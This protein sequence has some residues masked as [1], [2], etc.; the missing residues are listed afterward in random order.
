MADIR[1]FVAVELSA[2]VIDRARSLIEH[3]RPS[4][5][6][7]KW[8]EPHNMHLTLQFL[9]DV[10]E[11]QTAE[12]CGAVSE[13]IKEFPSFDV[14][15]AGA[16]AFPDARRPRT[17]WIGVR[18]GIEPLTRLQAAIEAALDELGFPG[19]D[20]RF[21]PHLT[22]GRVRQGGGPEVRALGQLVRQHAD[23]DAASATIDHVTVFSSIL[24]KAGPTYQALVRAP[25]AV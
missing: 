15:L 23:F 12:V 24:G 8:V 14:S 20:R 22:I 16:G 25:L 10:P 13:A 19:E 9:G 4:G 17:L 5:A 6:D 2:A 11:P 1:T 21:H 18:E 7:V 3:L